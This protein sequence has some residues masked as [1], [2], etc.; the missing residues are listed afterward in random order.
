[1]VLSFCR[2]ELPQPSYRSI[3]YEMCFALLYNDHTL[4]TLNSAHTDFTSWVPMCL[5]IKNYM[6]HH[7]TSSVVFLTTVHLMLVKHS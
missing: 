7:V 1:M 2:L 6:G 3:K 4:K 5:S